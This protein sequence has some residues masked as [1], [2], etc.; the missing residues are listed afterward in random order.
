ML[1]QHLKEHQNL[2]KKSQ[3]LMVMFM[4]MFIRFLCASLNF[5]SINRVW[6]S[7][8]SCSMI[9]P[10]NSLSLIKEASALVSWL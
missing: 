4:K 6:E 8:R 9:L 7:S 10:R 1:N 5:I 3:K 2:F